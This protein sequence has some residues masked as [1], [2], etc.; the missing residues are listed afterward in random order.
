MGMLFE[1]AIFLLGAAAFLLSVTLFVGLI[2]WLKD[3]FF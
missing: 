2:F 1:I 3:E